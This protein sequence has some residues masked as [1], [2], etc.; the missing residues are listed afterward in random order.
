MDVDIRIFPH[1]EPGSNGRAHNQIK[2]KCTP[3]KFKSEFTPEK[4]WERKMILSYWVSV[5]FQ[6]RAV[7]LPGGKNTCIQNQHSLFEMYFHPYFNPIPVFHP[8]H[9]WNCSRRF[10]EP[11]STLSKWPRCVKNCHQK[12]ET[13]SL[14]PKKLKHELWSISGHNSVCKFFS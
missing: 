13:Y 8:N 12:K 9:I 1:S 14:P 11:V 10:V 2:S 6:G 5:T 3:P 7:K 4:W